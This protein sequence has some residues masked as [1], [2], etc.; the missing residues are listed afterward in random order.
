MSLDLLT[1]KHKI[2]TYTGMF[3]YSIVSKNNTF[4]MTASKLYC[5]VKRQMAF[6]HDTYLRIIQFIVRLTSGSFTAS[7]S[8]L[9][10]EQLKATEST[11]IR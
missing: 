5:N 8:R 2:Y 10:N 3:C 4:C 11:I 7:L 9:T 6:Y 1:L